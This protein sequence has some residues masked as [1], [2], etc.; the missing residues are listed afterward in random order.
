[1][2]SGTSAAG[3]AVS[4]HAQAVLARLAEG[5]GVSAMR[6]AKDL[7]LPL[8]GVLRAVT[9]L[10]SPQSGWVALVHREGSPA[11]HLHLTPKGRALCTTTA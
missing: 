8:S 4:E 10:A 1:M 9:L 6:V 2:D 11:P 7:G 3:W 5:D